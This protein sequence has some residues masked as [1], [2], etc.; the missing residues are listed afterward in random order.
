MQWIVWV[1][2]GTP[3]GQVVFGVPVTVGPEEQFVSVAGSHC[4]VVVSLFSPLPVVVS[5]VP[6]SLPP[7]LPEPL[8]SPPRL[9]LST[10]SLD[11]SPEEDDVLSES[12]V[13]RF[14]AYATVPIL[15]ATIF[16]VTKQ[17]VN[18]IIKG[19]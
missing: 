2:L 19:L 12:R 8:V 3:S 6:V 16:E 15:V 17:N 1:I 14:L 10:L 9:D 7:P 11:L 5:P 13:E 18:I 4:C